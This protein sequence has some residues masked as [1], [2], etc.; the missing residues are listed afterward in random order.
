MTKTKILI[1]IDEVEMA[2]TIVK[3]ACNL[4]DR[5]NTEIT[6]LNVLE[7]TCAE[8]E[9]FLREPENFIKHESLKSEYYVI[10]N[11]LEQNNFDFKGLV[12]VEGI[13]SE[14]I[15]KMSKEQKYDLVVIGCNEKNVLEKILLGSTSYKVIRDS[16]CSV[17]VVKPHAEQ[18]KLSDNYNVLFATDGS[19][20]SIYATDYVKTILDKNRAKLSVLNVRVPFQAVLP[21]ESY[22]YIDITTLIKE[23]EMVSKD[24]VKQA[25]VKLMQNGFDVE[26]KLFLEGEPA[27]EI[28]KL[29]QNSGYA[30]NDYDLLV[31]G[32]HGKN[33]MSMFFMGSTSSKVYENTNKTV[34]IVKFLKINK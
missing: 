30:P 15:L 7:T 28:V 26:Q 8:E 24:I 19:E 10:E 20:H 12:F 6:L 18:K 1:A 25:T 29:A 13:A 27:A 2:E 17:L 32:S 31:I 14:V 11:F 16:K 23:A 5:Q 33:N 21:Q 3:T 34:L 4:I 22:S 9:L